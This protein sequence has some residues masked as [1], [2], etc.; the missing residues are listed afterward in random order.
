MKDYVT[1]EAT[2]SNLA[3]DIKTDISSD[4]VEHFLRMV[5]ENS[6]TSNN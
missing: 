2:S 6:N 5:G 1:R 4:G 3:I